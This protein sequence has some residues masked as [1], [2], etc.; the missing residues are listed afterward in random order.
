MDYFTKW[1]EAYAIPSQESPTLVEALVTNFICLF[2]VPQELHSDQGHNF[3][4]H[5][6]H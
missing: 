6:I 2:G 4:S 1:P 5:L 3:E